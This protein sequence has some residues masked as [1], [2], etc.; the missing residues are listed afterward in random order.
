MNGLKGVIGLIALAYFGFLV[1]KVALA[2]SHMTLDVASAA[3]YGFR[4]LAYGGLIFASFAT[5][6]YQFSSRPIYYLMAVLLMGQ[7]SFYAWVKAVELSNAPAMV[8]DQPA[9]APAPKPVTAAPAPVVA[10][11]VAPEPKPVATNAPTDDPGW[12]KDGPSGPVMITP[13]MAKYMNSDHVRT[14]QQPIPV[15]DV[16]ATQNETNNSTGNP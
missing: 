12:A 15:P 5:R 2:F 6:A 4:I 11:V 1:V 3:S 9:P 16:A 8:A 7:I 14:V 13:E 10:V